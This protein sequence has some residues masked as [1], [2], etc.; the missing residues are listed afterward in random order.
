V[1]AGA[2]VIAGAFLP[3]A[4]IAGAGAV[5]VVARAFPP[6][7]ACAGTGGASAS[8]G[9]SKLPCWGYQVISISLNIIIYHPISWAHLRVLV[10]V[11]HDV[12]HDVSCGIMI[13]D[14]T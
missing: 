3:F 5:G 2:G 14:T 10:F 4:A 8:G 12:Y 9:R 11:Y 1:V 13:H 6:F 7:A